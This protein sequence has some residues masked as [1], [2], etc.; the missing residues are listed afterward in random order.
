MGDQIQEYQERMIPRVAQL[1]GYQEGF[2]VEP[3]SSAVSVSLRYYD[4]EKEVCL[5]ESLTDAEIHQ[6]SYFYL[7][8]LKAEMQF[9]WDMAAD[10]SS[11]LGGSK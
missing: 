2:Y 11:K 10:I 6:I 4:W 1:V 9:D 5:P 8:S 3:G 7:E